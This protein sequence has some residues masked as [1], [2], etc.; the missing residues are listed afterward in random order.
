MD[1]SRLRELVSGRGTGAPRPLRELTYEPEGPQYAAAP[2]ILDLAR[3][4]GGRPIETRWGTV[5]VVERRHE[6]GERH[7]RF[8]VRDWLSSPD[9]DTLT[10]LDPSTRAA[11]TNGSNRLAFFDIETTGLSGG[12]GTLAFL[13]GIGWFDHDGFHTSQLLLTSHAAERALLAATADLLDG[14]SALV[15]YNGRCFDVPVLETRWAFHRMP[16]P[17]GDLPHVD[18]LHPARRLWKRRAE[19]EADRSCTLVALERLILEFV[20]QDDVA[21]FEIPSRYFQYL[22]RGDPR[23]LLPVLEHNRLDLLSLAAVTMATCRLV[24]DGAASARDAYECVALGRVF[25]HAGDPAKAEECYIRAAALEARAPRAE[26]LHRLAVLHRRAR[27]YGEAARLWEEVATLDSIASPLG[28]EALRAL[29]VH[30]EHRARDLMAARTYA[31]Q[32]LQVE[33]D[34]RHR[35]QVEYRLARLE[36]KLLVQ[37]KSGPAAAFLIPDS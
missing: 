9:Y 25:E 14:A 22:R 4:L 13:I 32:A 7:G 18:M 37:Q 2:S 30:H 11:D 20:R 15:T 28:R 36:R 17:I 19:A 3:V 27:R 35:Q 23:P 1:L 31:L 5:L 8:I 34:A 16:M 21:G 10:L 6:P 26:A 12:A 33:R 24:R 29:A